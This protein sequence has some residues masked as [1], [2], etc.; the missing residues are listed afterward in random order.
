MRSDRFK[1][2]T[3]PA[4]RRKGIWTDRSVREK[5]PKLLLSFKDFACMKALL[6][7]I[8]KHWVESVDNVCL[9]CKRQQNNILLR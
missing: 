3:E 4:R 8:F 6:G 5:A 2:R 7:Q 9:R 1:S